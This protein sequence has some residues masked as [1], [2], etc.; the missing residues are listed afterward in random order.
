MGENRVDHI[1]LGSE[2]LKMDGQIEKR[3]TRGK[4]V[5]GP[6]DDTREWEEYGE[7]SIIL[8]CSVGSPSN[9][10]CLPLPVFSCLE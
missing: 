9:F 3:G 7:D 4:K 10:V 1:F 2:R 6:N 8:L 5:D